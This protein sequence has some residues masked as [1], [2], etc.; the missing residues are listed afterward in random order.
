MTV[1]ALIGSAAALLLAPQSG[2]RTRRQIARTAESWGDS[3]VESLEDVRDEARDLAGKAARETRKLAQ[4][5]QAGMVGEFEKFSPAKQRQVS[6]LSQVARSPIR[7]RV[8]E[9]SGSLATVSV[10]SADGVTEDMVFVIYRGLD[11]IGDLRISKVEPS[12]AAGRIVR[13][14]GSVLVGDEVADEARFGMAR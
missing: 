4:S 13:S 5:P 10:G 6:P 14:T 2:R 9:V 7:G 1:G 8:T 11:Y 3:A 12:Q